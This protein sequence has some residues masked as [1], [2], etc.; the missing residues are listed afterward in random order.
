MEIVIKLCTVRDE[1]NNLAPG[2][3]FSDSGYSISDVPL[4]Q[5]AEMLVSLWETS[6]LKKEDAIKTIALR[7]E[8]M[9]RYYPHEL[10]GNAGDG[11]IER[12]V[13]K[14]FGIENGY[15]DGEALIHGVWY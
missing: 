3:H 4:E 7:L 13:L 8:H 2:V 6:G 1:N 5:A 11:L 15:D 14:H 9:E 12:L 10:L